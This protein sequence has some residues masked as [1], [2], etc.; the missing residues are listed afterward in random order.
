MIRN[1]NNIVS[2]ADFF[3]SVYCMSQNLYLILK[4]FPYICAMKLWTRECFFKKTNPL[5]ID[6]IHSILDI[7]FICT[8][9]LSNFNSQKSA[10]HWLRV[11]LTTRTGSR[12]P[13]S[14]FQRGHLH[15]AGPP[16]PAQSIWLRAPRT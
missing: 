15:T 2:I 13:R 8:T 6:D 1:I 3:L 12:T 10:R 5:K 14:A 9:N 7:F 11:K 4:T 16:H